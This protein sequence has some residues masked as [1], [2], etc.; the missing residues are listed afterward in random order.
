M[1]QGVLPPG[2]VA[3]R[4]CLLSEISFTDLFIS[5]GGCLLSETLER[6]NLEI[7][8]RV[9]GFG[10]GVRERVRVRTGFRFRSTGIIA[11]LEE[12]HSMKEDKNRGRGG[13]VQMWERKKGM[14]M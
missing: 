1:G 10:L 7:S 6:D 14:Y 13:E 2:V 11:F 9:F 4:G 5:C 3:L 12:P 8:S